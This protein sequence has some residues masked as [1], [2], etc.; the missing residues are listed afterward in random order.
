MIEFRLY[1]YGNGQLYKVG[2]GKTGPRPHK[3]KSYEECFSHVEKLK[4]LSRS[5]DAQYVVVHSL[6]S[7]DSKIISII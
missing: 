2:K 6:G 5:S 4:S 1:T 3:F 7:Y